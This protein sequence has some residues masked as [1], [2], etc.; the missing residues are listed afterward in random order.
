MRFRVLGPLEVSENG[1]LVPLGGPRQRAVLAHLLVR[2]DQVV[3]AEVLIDAVWGD[4]P[5]DAARNTLQSYVSRLRSVLG[6]DRIEG[7]SPGYRFV[8]GPDK[9]ELARFEALVGEA[10]RVLSL[11][12][13]ASGEL[14]VEAEGLWR[15]PALADLAQEPSL[16]GEIARI[17]E[18]PPERR[19][20]QDRRRPGGG[21]H[22]ADV[23]ELES[24]V[25]EHPLRERLWGQLVL[26]L[27]RSGRQAEALAA[28]RRARDALT[29]ELGSIRRASTNT[30]TSGCSARTPTSI[31]AASRCAG[32]G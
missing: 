13:R 27:Y 7:R 16:A 32:T 22:A 25:N 1:H 4:T 11:D 28:Y 26:A 17:E 29:Q 19:R 18:L 5:P 30:C 24:L 14:F 2:A 23:G 20:R 6:P 15:G 31:C 9:I 8:A 21:R 10:R 3:P 12:P